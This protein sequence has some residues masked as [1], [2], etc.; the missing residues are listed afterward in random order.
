MLKNSVNRS[1]LIFSSTKLSSYQ[2]DENLQYLP[3]FDCIIENQLSRLY[4][5]HKYIY[6]LYDN[7]NYLATTSHIQYL[8]MH[9]SK[10]DSFPK[11]RLVPYIFPC[12]LLLNNGNM[13]ITQWTFSTIE[14]HKKFSSKFLNYFK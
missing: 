11:N 7:M 3:C 12:F 6:N 9:Q 5:M 1:T 10:N 14:F 8:Y 4:C 13:V 2:S